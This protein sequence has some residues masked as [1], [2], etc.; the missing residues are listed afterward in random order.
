MRGFNSAYEILE[1]EKDEPYTF[2][3]T[4]ANRLINLPRNPLHIVVPNEEQIEF[5]NTLF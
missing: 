3:Y 5:A 4:K 1:E 2:H